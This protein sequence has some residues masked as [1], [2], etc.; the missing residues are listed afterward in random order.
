MRW[1]CLALA[2]ISTFVGS[3]CAFRMGDFSLISSQNVAFSPEPIRR[4]VEG[5]DCV[6]TLIFIP[7]GGL[8]PNLEEAMD[9]AMEQV[10]EGNVMMN[11]AVYSDLIFTYVFNRQCTRVRGEVGSLR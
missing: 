5:S 1:K 6:Y 2:L 9:R 10:P 11:V 4:G 7:I 3:G 8:V